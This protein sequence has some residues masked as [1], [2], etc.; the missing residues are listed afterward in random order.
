M[1][2]FS[3]GDYIDVKERL[4]I[5]HEQ[6]PDGSIQ[7]EFK[8]ILEH[9]PDFIWGIAYAYRNPDDPRPAIGTACELA[10]GKTS[11]TRGSELMNLETSAWGRAIAALGLGLGGSGIATAQEVESAKARQ[12]PTNKSADGDEL[13][14]DKQ[15]NYIKASFNGSIAEMSKFVDEFK[16]NN[17]I[18]AEHK[19]TKVE[20]SLLI[21][22]L[23]NAGYQPI[24]RKPL[25]PESKD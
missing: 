5:F 2:N 3:L 15:F 18:P 14:T 17:D 4:K 24:T 6:Y 21:D 7:F 19:L 1:S 22:A 10:T 9:N 16:I 8:G 23:K 20:A 11:F 25:D 12:Y 13:M